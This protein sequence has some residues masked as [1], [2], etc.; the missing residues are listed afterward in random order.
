MGGAE[1]QGLM[2]ARHLKEFAGADVLFAGFG[3]PGRAADACDDL[4]IPWASW[5]VPVA[6][7]R[8]GLV[9]SLVR[10]AGRARAARPD[11]L[12]PY[13]HPPN[14][15]CGV[16]WRLARAGA[17]I[18]NQRDAGMQRLSGRLERIAV[19]NVSSVV[20]N[21]GSGVDFLTGELGVPRA[22]IHLVDNG[23]EC[24]VDTVDGA[25]ARTRY[26]VPADAFVGAMVANIHPHKDHLTLIRAWRHVTDAQSAAG[27]R[28][29]L[30]LAGHLWST[31]PAVK[32]L[33]FDLELGPDSVRF[34]GSVADVR[35]VY[36]CSDICVFS[37]KREGVPNGVLEAMAAGLAVAATDIEG[38]RHAVGPAGAEWL[39]VPGDHEGLA[40][41][42]VALAADPQ[43]RA[44][45]GAA[46]RERIRDIFAPERMCSEMTKVIVGALV[47]RSAR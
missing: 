14:V 29:V 13:T 10:T 35:E 42:I 23:V 26:G 33:A 8:S 16:V 18:W 19:G 41:R 3:E 5:P 12:M 47:N 22:G 40:Q 24:C 17:C 9:K 36:A 44:Y 28:A 7:T 45:L 43:L 32:A 39:A 27:R 2:L 1:R 15:L 38:I 6:R 34:L 25:A 4:G 11:V 21:S 37:S 20:S 46:G 30:L 31:T